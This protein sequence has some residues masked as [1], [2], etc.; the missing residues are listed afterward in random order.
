MPVS[1]NTHEIQCD[2]NLE[3]KSFF[4]RS[5]RQFVPSRVSTSCNRATTWLLKCNP[6]RNAEE[7]YQELLESP[8]ETQQYKDSTKQIELD[9]A[10]TYPDEQ[11]FSENSKGQAALR[12]VL[13]AFSKYDH[14]LGYVQGMNFIVAALLWH[15]SEVDAFWLFIGLMEEYELR[16]IFLPRLPG[17]SKHC[18]IIQLLILDLLPN[19]HR[20]FAEHRISSEMYATDWLFTMFGSVVPVREMVNILDQFFRKGWSFIYRFVIAILKCL[21]ET[22]L[23]ARDS[24]EI[25]GPLKITHQS[26]REWKHFLELLDGGKGKIGWEELIERSRTV[27]I[28]E[29]Y[30]KLLHR[31][32]NVETGQ[33]N[34]R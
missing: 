7:I 29:N 32:F 12:R 11:Y 1:I 8:L 26:Q 22:I 31:N 24:I 4:T 16:D 17:L 27:D 20:Q 5:Y 10:R 9:L 25:L 14:Y 28:D 30:I 15:S 23:Q 13:Y 3:D 21:E 19:V 6:P 34:L 2:C 33:F 18:Q